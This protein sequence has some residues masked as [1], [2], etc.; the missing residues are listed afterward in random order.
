MTLSRVREARASSPRIEMNHIMFCQNCR[1][2]TLKEECGSCHSKTVIPK[3]AKYGP[4]DPYASYRR[5]AKEEQLK[6]RGWL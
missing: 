1:A 2:Y 6:A 3:P 5:K 4:Q